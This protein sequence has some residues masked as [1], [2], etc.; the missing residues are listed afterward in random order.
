MQWVLGGSVVGIAY[1]VEQRLPP[2]RSP[3]LWKILF[4]P[5]GFVAAYALAMPQWTLF[6]MVS[7]GLVLLAVSFVLPL[8]STKQESETV[9]QLKEKMRKCC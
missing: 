3:L 9:E 2:E 1:Q 4:I 5:A 8:G 7:V 6:A